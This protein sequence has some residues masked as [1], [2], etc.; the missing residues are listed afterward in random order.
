MSAHYR[1]V[2][3]AVET[4]FLPLAE[5]IAFF[6]DEAADGIKDLTPVGRLWDTAKKIPGLMA[7]RYT[8]LQE[9]EAILEYVTMRANRKH[10][11]HKR[12]YMENYNRTLSEKAAG[13]YA[14]TEQDVFDLR[15]LSNEVAMVRNTFLGLTKGLEFLHFQMNNLTKLRDGGIEDAEF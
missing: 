4:D 6:E 8:Q 7:F 9:I 10:A 14:S 5:A 13:E 15:L 2:V 1:K 11:E 12:R 3:S